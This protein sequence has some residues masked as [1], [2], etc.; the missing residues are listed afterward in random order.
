MDS[1]FR[2]EPLKI[3]YY[4]PHKNEWTERAMPP[5]HLLCYMGSWHLIAFCTVFP[6]H[7]GMNRIKNKKG[8]KKMERTEFE[9]ELEGLIHKYSLQSKPDTPDFMLAEYLINCLNNFNVI[10][11]KR[12][13]W[14]VNG[15]YKSDV[16]KGERETD[17]DKNESDT[18]RIVYSGFEKK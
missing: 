4:T 12:Q 5:L 1:L 8:E 13:R 6:A 10:T 11:R 7:A 15:G 3:S 2:N 16:I 14:Y 9:R 17:K 18:T